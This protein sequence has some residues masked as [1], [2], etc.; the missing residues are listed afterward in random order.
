MEQKKQPDFYTLNIAPHSVLM[1]DIQIGTYIFWSVHIPFDFIQEIQ[2]TYRIEEMTGSFILDQL[3]PI[4]LLVSGQPTNTEYVQLLYDLEFRTQDGIYRQNGLSMGNCNFIY[5]PFTFRSV[6]FFPIDMLYDKDSTGRIQLSYYY[7]EQGPDWKMLGKPR[8]VTLSYESKISS[9]LY[10]AVDCKR[11]VVVYQGTIIGDKGKIKSIPQST[12]N[13][14][15]VP[16]GIDMGWISVEVDSSRVKW[17]KYNTVEVFL[18]TDDTYNNSDFPCEMLTFNS[19]TGSLYWGYLGNTSSKQ[20]YYWK[21]S[22]YVK[23]FL[24]PITTDIHQ[25]PFNDYIVLPVEPTN[26]AKD[27]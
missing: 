21:A 13:Q 8:Q 27:I 18:Y 7:S 17:S 4:K 11:A 22:Y 25:E 6:Q 23:D 26:K 9:M 24:D 10:P 3:N 12:S 20:P 16:I 2:V 15:T 19:T 5:N 14:N 1:N